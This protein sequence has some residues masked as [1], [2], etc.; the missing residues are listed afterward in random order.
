MG[1]D[2]QAKG[3]WLFVHHSSAPNFEWDRRIPMATTTI[4]LHSI[5]S[6]VTSYGWLHGGY[7]PS[8]LCSGAF[9]EV[10]RCFLDL[11]VR[12]LD[13]WQD[14]VRSRSDLAS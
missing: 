6:A 12:R 3:L 8:D 13:V 11:F 7:K 2:C 4:T 5:G 14:R 10:N 1:P 9:V